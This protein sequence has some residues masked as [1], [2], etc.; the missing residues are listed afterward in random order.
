MADAAFRPRPGRGLSARI[1]LLTCAFV[2][3]GEVLIYLPSIARFRLVFLEERLAAA[4]LA[5]LSLEAAPDGRLAPE[6]EAQL[7]TY[8]GV[9]AVTLWRSGAERMLGRVEPVDQVVDLAERSPARLIPDA[10]ATLVAEPGRR[11]RVIGPSAH[12]PGVLVDVI[13]PEAPLRRAMLDYSSR[14]LTLSVFLSLLVALLLVASLFRL[15]VR[16]VRALTRRLELFRL[17][18][19]DPAGEPPPSGRGDEIGIVEQEL[20]RM[21]AGLRQ[22]LAEK[23]RLAALGAAVSELAHDLKNMLA[24]AVLVSDRLETSADPA[25]R[26]VAPRLVASLDRAIRLCTDTLAFARGRPREA[27]PGPVELAPLVEEVRLSALADAPTVTLAL[28]PPG[29]LALVAD[30]DHLYRVLLNLV[31]NAREALGPRPGTVRITARGD[32]RSVTIV[33]ADDGPGI[34]ESLRGRLFTSFKASGKPG[35]SGLGLAI[36]RELMRAQGGDLV[37]ERTGPDGTLFTLTLPQPPAVP[38]AGRQAAE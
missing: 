15:V 19:E 34:P 14:I 20:T 37:L 29:G 32:A 26:R 2:L 22:A 28:D 23:A 18:P 11:L 33:V 35:G 8:A 38:A 4:E 24:T 36:S 5:A 13:V 10:L 21:Q 6:L 16:P 27:R 9:V 30:R 3:L 1:L 17:R 31:R 12:E 25:V 7:L